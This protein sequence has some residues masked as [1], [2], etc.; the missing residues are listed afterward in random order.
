MAG[1]AKLFMTLH[2]NAAWLRLL[3]PGQVQFQNAV[4]IAGF[5]LSEGA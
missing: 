3:G 5:Q 1:I 2:F 4:A